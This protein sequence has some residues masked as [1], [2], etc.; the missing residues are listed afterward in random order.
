MFFVRVKRYADPAGGTIT[1][2]GIFLDSRRNSAYNA[3]MDEKNPDIPLQNSDTAGRDAREVEHFT[4]L[5][6]AP[7]PWWGNR[8]RAGQMRQDMRGTK[9]IGSC[10]LA[11]GRRALEGGCSTGEFT[12]RLAPSGASITA[13]DI[14][15]KM[16]SR[17][18]DVHDFENAAFEVANVEELPYPDNS[19]DAVVGNAILHHLDLAKSL[20]E[21]LRVLKP[22]GR[23]AFSEP[24]YVNPV[25]FVIVTFHLFDN[26]PDETAFVRW[27]LAKQLREAGFRNVRV[28]P[29]DFLLPLVPSFLATP[30]RAAGSLLEKIPVVKEVAGS[31]FITGEK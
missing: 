11:P 27:R 10:K 29:F 16:I 13:T 1:R 24:N 22:G 14:T 9:T 30:V 7:V 25:V 19:F 4:E 18:N 15:P 31:L 3:R 5:A 6:E 23:I 12:R 21:I 26:S 8:T 17:A 28:A 2:R 20:P